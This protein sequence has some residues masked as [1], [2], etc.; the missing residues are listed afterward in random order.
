MTYQEKIILVRY[1]MERS[2]ESFR[3]AEILCNEM[4]YIETVNRLYYACFYAITALMAWHE[5]SAKTHVGVKSFFNKEFIASS[6]LE[7]KHGVFF[8]RIFTARHE[9]DYEDFVIIEEQTVLEYMKQG[10][11]FLEA[12]QQHFYTLHVPLTST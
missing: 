1:R 6:V 2:Q 7:T 4:L 10:R 11:L 8:N 9:D 12:I 3:A 5:T